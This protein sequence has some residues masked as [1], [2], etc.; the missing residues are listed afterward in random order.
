MTTGKGVFWLCGAG[1]RGFSW[2]K[3]TTKTPTHERKREIAE[4]P[5]NMKNTDGG[6]RKK[7]KNNL[8]SWEFLHLEGIK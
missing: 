5:Q 1:A 7:L 8:K 2:R 4:I 3:A 6:A